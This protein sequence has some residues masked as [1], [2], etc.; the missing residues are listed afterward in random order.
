M[1]FLTR[2]LADVDETY[3]QHMWHAV[4]FAAAMFAGALACLVHAFVPFVFETTGSR[5]ITRLNDRMVTNRRLQTPA[6]L[7]PSKLQ[8]AGR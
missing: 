6:H 1:R 8:T 5:C 4:R 7:K 3:T 2:H